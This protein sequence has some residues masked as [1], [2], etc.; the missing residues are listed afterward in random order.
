VKKYYFIPLLLLV[1]SL[2]ANPIYTLA[3]EISSSVSSSSSPSSSEEE[4]LVLAVNETSGF[5][6]VT[7]YSENYRP[8]G[9][10]FFNSSNRFVYLSNGGGYTAG[11][12]FTKTKIFLADSENSG[13]ST[14]FEMGLYAAYG[15]ADGFTF[16]VSRDIN[17]LGSAGGSI[18]YGG[19]GN[20]IAIIFDNFDNGG[21]PPLCLAL[22][23]NGNQGQCFQY[24]GPSSGSFRIWIDY[25][26]ATQVLQVRINPSNYVRPVN[27]TRTWTGVNVDQIGNEFFTGFTASTGGF[28]QYA[29]LQSWYFAASYLANGIDPLAAGTFVTDNVAPIAPFIQP[30]LRNG[31]WFFKEDETRLEETGL[32]F[33]YT[34]G[35]NNQF[36]F[37]NQNAQATFTGSE[38]LVYLYALDAAGNRS[39]FT[40]YRYHRATYILNYTNAQNE[41]F[42]YPEANV[43]FP[44]TQLVD[45]FVPTRPGFEFLGWG[46]TPSQN[47]NLLLKDAFNADKVYFARWQMVDATI[48][49]NTNGGS[50]IPNTITNV[51]DGLVLPVPPTKPFNTFAGWFVDAALTQP[52]DLNQYD[53]LSTT[54]YAKWTIDTYSV[55]YVSST[56]GS[57]T[58]VTVEHGSTITVPL[59]PTNEP[60]FQFDGWYADEACT[61]V[62]NFNEGV[63]QDTSIYAKWVD[64][65][66]NEAF[67]QSLNALNDPLSTHDVDALQLSRALFS[68][69][70]PDQ[71]RY[72]DPIYLA[73]LVALENHMINLLAVE[74]VVLLIDALPRIV[75]LEDGDL[76]SDAVE[77][78][79]NL[80]DEQKDLFPMDREHHLGDLVYQYS[81]LDQAKG[82]EMLTVAIPIAYGID[83]IQTIEQAY[84]AFLNLTPEEQAMVSPESKSRLFQAISQLNQLKNANDFVSL[85]LA[86]GPS[87]TIDDDIRIQAA[88]DA[89]ARL[90]AED[91]VYIN[92]E[93]IQLLATYA[94]QHQDLT[95][96]LPVENQLL[97]L[98]LN[99]SLSHET[100]IRSAQAAFD[101]LSQ[102]QQALVSAEAKTRLQNANQQL[103]VLLQPVDPETPTP[104]SEQPEGLYIPWII[105]VVLAGWGGGYY[106][107]QLRKK[108][109]L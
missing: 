62:F 51:R 41:F 31:T 29:I 44:D 92:L 22:G 89:Y 55:T 9:S 14:F 85:V 6:N 95:I 34:F 3:S 69:L 94:K 107:V 82:V 1:G 77:A 28:S 27:P 108:Y 99:V 56:F 52:F 109:L 7:N 35:N 106:L 16:I 46:T 88:L 8:F 5:K 54:L 98:P 83:D 42:F 57:N 68:E 86:I 87:I 32:N 59:V 81:N 23:V 30:Y 103:N 65:R 12:F 64:L 93:Y 18:G 13:F 66:P 53:Y 40:T 76:I 74:A 26:R 71:I 24:P 101:A 67:I 78:Y 100:A 84:A 36:F 39:P 20:S 72:L 102:D 91:R 43:N 4:L 61:Q 75:S 11:S 70:T 10:T 19:I 47:T 33:L 25:I 15:Y 17:V 49:F 63:T 104:P 97:A 96:A 73:Q 105:I 38:R 37:L 48:Q 80:T 79:A 2:T 90:S 50:E 45:L 60:Y 21:Q 58:N